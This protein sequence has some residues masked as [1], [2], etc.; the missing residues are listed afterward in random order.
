M[1]AS[2][3]RAVASVTSGVSSVGMGEVEAHP[4]RMMLL[5]HADQRARHPHGQHDRHFG[6]EP[7]ELDMLDGAEPPQ[8]IVEP[9]VGQRQRVAARDQHVADLGMVGDV[10]E[11]LLPLR[12]AEGVVAAG[13]AHHARA[14]AVAAIGRAEAGG[15]EQHA[16]GIAVHQAGHHAMAVL[17]ERIVGLAGR[18]QIF[19][20]DRD[21]G[22]AQRLERVFARHQARVIGRDAE[23]QRALMADHRVALVVRQH[24]D[25]LELGERADAR[26]R[27][28]AP[29]VPL[30]ELDLGIEALAEG[31]RQRPD[32]EALEARSERDQMRPRAGV[33]AGVRALMG[34]CGLER[35]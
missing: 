9:L 19:G 1:P 3:S 31:A 2:A 30:G 21:M 32:G 16:V 22:A 24:E 5:E 29:V 14:G 23:R 35:S 27:L 26:A 4:Q 10:S 15:E 7:H 13:L 34:R 6:A 12:P 25:A 11:R 8:Q 33:P 20:A 18:L 28:P 17:A